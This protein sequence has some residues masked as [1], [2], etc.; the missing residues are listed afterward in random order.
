MGEREL[1]EKYGGK[2]AKAINRAIRAEVPGGN[3]ALDRLTNL[4]GAARHSHWEDKVGQPTPEAAAYFKHQRDVVDRME[5]QVRQTWGIP[6]ARPAGKRP[7]PRQGHVKP[8]RP[9]AKASAKKPTTA[10]AKRPRQT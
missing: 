8:R 6:P 2:L 5:A 9:P 4:A 3:E 7:P 10:G 1:R